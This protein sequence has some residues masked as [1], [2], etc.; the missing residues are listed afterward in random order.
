MLV[1]DT[2]ALSAL[3]DEKKPDHGDAR[4]VMQA[5]LLQRAEDEDAE[6]AP[7]FLVP[8]LVLYEIRRGLLHRDHQRLLRKLAQLLRTLAAVEP[9]DTAMAER[10]AQ[11]WAARA[12]SG[13]QAGG[14][15]LLIAS[16]AAVLGADVVT[17]DDG[18][19]NVGQVR[20]LR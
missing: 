4:R 14:L 15:D 10:A 5:R 6:D 9:F 8:A 2:S 7:L 20:L 3:I 16:T 18:F 19:P 1:L 13:R 11:A 17:A 12:S